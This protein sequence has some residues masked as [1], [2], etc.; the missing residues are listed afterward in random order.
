MSYFTL[1][2]VIEDVLAIFEGLREI[3]IGALRVAASLI[4]EVLHVSITF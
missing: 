1:Y 3:S 2:C 4:N